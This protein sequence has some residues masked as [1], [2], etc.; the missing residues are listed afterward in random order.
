MSREK[1]VVLVRINS[2]RDKKDFR[3]I[4]VHELMHVFCGK[5]EIDGEH[6]I[7]IYGSGTTPDCD[8]EDAEYDGMIV[9]GYKIWSEFIAQY[10]AVSLIDEE[11]IDFT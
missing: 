3:R 9:A 8:L 6:F 11:S 4:I 7:D 2:K 1:S 5:L 10:Y